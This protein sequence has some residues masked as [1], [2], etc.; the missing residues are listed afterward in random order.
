MTTRPTTKET[1]VA[2]KVSTP[3]KISGVQ[4][5]DAASAAVQGSLTV[6]TTW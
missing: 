3:L 4:A 2:A 1:A 6:L 5:V